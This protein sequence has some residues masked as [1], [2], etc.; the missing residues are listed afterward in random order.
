VGGLHG[1]YRLLVKALEGFLSAAFIV[2]TLD[3]LW[4]VFSRYVVGE[5][6]RWTEELAI[7]LLVWISLLGA[8]V[9]YAERGH[10]GVDYFVAKMDP[11]AQKVAAISIELLVSS[12]ALF[13][14]VL[15]G[16][17][18]VEKTLVSGQMSP[19]LDIKMGY[20]YLAAPI[21]GVFFLAFSVEH[22]LEIFKGSIDG[23][24]SEAGES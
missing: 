10:L 17:T 18:L 8:A 19:A 24:P 15:G 13:A 11:A 20:V 9:T 21:S 12:F 4:G 16:F 5:Q 23:E 1:A 14:L 7:Y 22:L 3:V 2:L 6:S